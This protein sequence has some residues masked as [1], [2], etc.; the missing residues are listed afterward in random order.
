MYKLRM[1]QNV[2]HKIVKD[3]YTHLCIVH[4]LTCNEFEFLLDLSLSFF[5]RLKRNELCGSPTFI[6]W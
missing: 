6:Q 5:L 4:H 3:A 1:L 2:Y